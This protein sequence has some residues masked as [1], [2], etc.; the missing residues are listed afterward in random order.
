MYR[1]C[2]ETRRIDKLKKFACTFGKR[3]GGYDGGARV[4]VCV[5]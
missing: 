4:C 1:T 2:A 5:V 3:E